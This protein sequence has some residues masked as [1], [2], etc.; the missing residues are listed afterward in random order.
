[1]RQNLKK[2]KHCRSLGGHF[3]VDKTLD[4]VRRFYFWPKMQVDVRKFVQSCTICQR[5]KGSASNAGLYQPLPIPNRP[6]ESLSM[7]FVLGL[8]RT[9]RGYDSVFVKCVKSFKSDPM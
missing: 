7:D 5:A 2:E 8:P 6:W 4:Q 3:G 1:M 9:Q